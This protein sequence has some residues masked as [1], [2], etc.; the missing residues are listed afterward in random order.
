MF[1]HYIKSELNDHPRI[2]CLFVPVQERLSGTVM[3]S[4]QNNS[5]AV[6]LP[7]ENTYSGRE[8]LPRTN[9]KEGITKSKDINITMFQKL[10]M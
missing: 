3:V 5:R 10:S 8:M 2:V 6:L 4:H 1:T 9:L 7:T